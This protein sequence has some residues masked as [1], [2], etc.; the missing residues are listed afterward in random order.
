[1]PHPSNPLD[2]IRAHSFNREHGQRELVSRTFGFLPFVLARAV[3]KL[4]SE[5]SVCLMDYF[6]FTRPVRPN[7]LFGV[8][9]L[10]QFLTAKSPI[11]RKKP[12]KRVVIRTLESRRGAQSVVEISSTSHCSPGGPEVLISHSG[13]IRSDERIRTSSHQTFAEVGLGSSI[14]TYINYCYATSGIH[15]ASTTP[16]LSDRQS[17]KASLRNEL[18]PES[19][20]FY[21]PKELLKNP[22][23]QATDVGRRESAK[24]D[25]ENLYIRNGG[26]QEWWLPLELSI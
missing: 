24:K 5:S 6:G 7:G 10:V 11:A 15:S 16:S 26:R 3:G 19:V 9:G 17:S 2:D 21:A 8:G 14:P 12:C 18:K 13:L 25:P 22:K 4:A 1:M 23:G 20:Q